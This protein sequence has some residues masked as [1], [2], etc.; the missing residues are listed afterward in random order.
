MFRFK[1]HCALVSPFASRTV[2]QSMSSDSVRTTELEHRR[3]C[4]EE[5]QIEDP[6]G[7]CDHRDVSPAVELSSSVAASSSAQSMP[8][9]AF[10]VPERDETLLQPTHRCGHDTHSVYRARL[11]DGQICVVKFFKKQPKV[12]ALDTGATGHNRMWLYSAGIHD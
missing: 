9:A 10:A 2:L 7:L 8:P 4:M 5:E 1:S 3:E 11:I 6:L 12:L